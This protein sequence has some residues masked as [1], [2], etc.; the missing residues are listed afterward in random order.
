MRN[1][2]I[3]KNTLKI[4]LLVILLGS[5]W[6]I[7]AQS[8]VL[9]LDTTYLDIIG[10]DARDGLTA[11]YTTKV[12]QDSLE[13]MWIGSLVGLNK[14]NGVTFETFI[15]DPLNKKSLVNDN[16][17]PIFTDSYNRLWLVSTNQ[18]GVIYNNIEDDFNKLILEINDY[19]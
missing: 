11:G 19:L 4:V 6:T 2:F 16:V 15:N 1:Q 9:K 14:N 7:F 5:S 17:F 18:Q 13:N 3:V 8:N 12:V 10:F